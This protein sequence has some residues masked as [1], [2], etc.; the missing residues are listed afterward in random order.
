MGWRD[1]G[2]GLGACVSEGQRVLREDTWTHYRKI[3]R[4]G[5]HWSTELHGSYDRRELKLDG[6][7]RT[8]VYASPMLFVLFS[9]KYGCCGIILHNRA[10]AR[11]K[12]K[13]RSSVYSYREHLYACLSYLVTG[14]SVQFPILV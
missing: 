2:S 12:G 13:L 8:V 4:P 6:V 1:L 5:T 3:R 11:R 14:S 9:C 10:G 7:R